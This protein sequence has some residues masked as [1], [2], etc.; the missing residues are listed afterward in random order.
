MYLGSYLRFLQQ[1]ERTRGDTF[2][3]IS[4]AHVDDADVY[5]A[6]ASFARHCAAH[7]AAL[8]DAVSRYHPTEPEPAHLHVPE[9]SPPRDGPLGLLR[10]LQD[11]Y[12][13]THLVDL[14]W[15]LARQAAYGARDRDLI[16]TADRCIPVT[17]SHLAWLRTHLSAAAPQTLLVAT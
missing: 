6:T 11:A 8:A 4:A 1:A 17:A 7:V 15:T 9:P 13:L 10:D 3:Q 12:Q 2:D 16:A 14:T 5:Y